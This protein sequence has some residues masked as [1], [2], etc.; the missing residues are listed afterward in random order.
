MHIFQ[1]HGNYYYTLQVHGNYTQSVLPGELEGAVEVKSTWHTT[2][3]V[4][5]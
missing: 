3:L 4:A 5:A 1:I 2:G